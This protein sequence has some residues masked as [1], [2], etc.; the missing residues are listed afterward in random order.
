MLV[1]HIAAWYIF[2]LRPSDAKNKIPQMVVKNGEKSPC[3][4]GKPSP[5]Q[6]IQVEIS[7]LKMLGWKLSYRIIL[8][9]FHRFPKKT[10]KNIDFGYSSHHST[11]DLF[12]SSPT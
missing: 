9:L 1:F 11:C 7:W 4:I 6:Q 3:G 2:D 12:Y 5:E 10:S 8:R